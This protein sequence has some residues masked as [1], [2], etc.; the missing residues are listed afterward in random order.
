MES[1][2][3]LYQQGAADFA[4]CLIAAKNLAAGCEATVTFDETAPPGFT[5]IG[6]R[7]DAHDPGARRNGYPG[8]FAGGGATCGDVTALPGQVRVRPRDRAGAAI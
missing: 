7:S 6:E 3:Y 5:D 4:D 1:A 8:R 2:L